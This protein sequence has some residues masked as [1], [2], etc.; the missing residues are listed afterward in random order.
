MTIMQSVTAAELEAVSGGGLLAALGAAAKKIGSFLTRNKK[1]IGLGVGTGVT[2]NLITSCASGC[3]CTCRIP[4]TPPVNT[5][6]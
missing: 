6:E 5:G 1:T 4:A 2:A 3:R